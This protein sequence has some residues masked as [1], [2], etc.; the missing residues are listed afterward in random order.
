[1]RMRAAVLGGATGWH[2]R[3]LVESLRRAGHDA[4]VVGWHELGV[5]IGREESFLPAAVAGADVVVVRGMPSGRLEDVIFRMDVLGRLAR[6]RR[7]VNDPRSLEVAIDKYLCLARLHD[8]GVPVPR[9]I[10]AQD[11]AGIHA[12]WE[13]LGGDAVVKPLFG[14]E[15]RGIERLSS[16][17]ALAPWLDA[18]DRAVP[19]GAVCYLQEFIAHPGWDVRVLVVGRH[20]FGMRRIGSHDWRLNV[21]R[22]ARPEAWAVP[23]DWVDLAIRS[24]SAVGAEIAGVD[25][26]PSA[27]GPRV[28]EVN[29]TPGWKGIEA[30]T[31]QDVAGTI[32]RHLAEG[33]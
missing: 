24:A 18:A 15:G 29:G 2:G 5:E 4:V 16:R 25:I 12:A 19:P 13:M 17:A 30:V 11:S 6:T 33:A 22:G 9:T 23:E 1:M 32:V 31:N 7:V 27:A 3:R 21:S 26:V 28:V 20:I 8:A 10:V 14:S